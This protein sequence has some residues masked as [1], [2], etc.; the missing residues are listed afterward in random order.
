MEKINRIS[1]R[2][3]QLWVVLSF[4][5]AV[6]GNTAAADVLCQT[7]TIWCHTTAYPCD[8]IEIPEGYHC[9]AQISAPEDMTLLHDP[10]LF[11][12]RVGLD[13]IGILQPKTVAPR[14]S[15][16]VLTEPAALACRGCAAP[17]VEPPVIEAEAR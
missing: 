3:N 17:Q 14:V 7:G 5:L 15:T 16:Q 11:A 12:A 4:G 2:S 8:D 10:Q 13:D 9:F 1:R 6:I